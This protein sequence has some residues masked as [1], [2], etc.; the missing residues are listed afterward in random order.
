MYEQ[1]KKIYRFFIYSNLSL[2]ISHTFVCFHNLIT[3]KLKYN[4]HS[5]LKNHIM[6]ILVDTHDDRSLMVRSQASLNRE[7]NKDFGTIFV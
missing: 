1:L 4:S 3:S 7:A 2:S 6:K 5:T